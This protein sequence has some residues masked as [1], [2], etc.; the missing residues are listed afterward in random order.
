MDQEYTQ[1][2]NDLHRSIVA[3]KTPAIRRDLMIMYRHCLDIQTQLSMESV[4]CRRLHKVTSK[5][6]E[7]SKKMEKSIQNLDDYLVYGILS[8]D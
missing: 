4:N 3:I 2:L 7:I 5:Y 6:L 1:K 8:K